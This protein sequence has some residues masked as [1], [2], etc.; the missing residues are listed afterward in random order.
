MDDLDK[1]IQKR[2]QRDLAFAEG[3]ESGY[4]EFLI[5]VL[6]KEAIVG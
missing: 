6:L 5:G 2:K 1:Y 3:Y 4:Q